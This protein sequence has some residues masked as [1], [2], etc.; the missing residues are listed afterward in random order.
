MKGKD[1]L[2]QSNWWQVAEGKLSLE[3]GVGDGNQIKP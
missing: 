2:N 1:P 3:S